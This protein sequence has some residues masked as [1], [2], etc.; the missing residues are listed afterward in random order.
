MSR[1]TGVTTIIELTRVNMM[2]GNDWD[3]WDD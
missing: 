3:D 2:T 1:M